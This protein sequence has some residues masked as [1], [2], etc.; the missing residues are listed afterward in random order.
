MAT[1]D[2][3]LILLKNRST[4]LRALFRRNVYPRAVL[5]DKCPDPISVKPTITEQHC[6]RFQGRHQGGNKT[7]VVCLASGQRETDRQRTVSTS[8]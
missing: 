5:A 1:P 7:V 3:A 4:K 6:S 8:A 2:T